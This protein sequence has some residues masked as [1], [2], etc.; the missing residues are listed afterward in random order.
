MPERKDLIDIFKAETEDHLTRLDNGIVALEK[1]P[2]NLELV[3]GSESG[4]AY[5][6][7]RGPGVWIFRDSGHRPP[8][9]GYL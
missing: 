1:E 8:D 6:E 4:S 7:G 5:P 3:K 2:D 9:R